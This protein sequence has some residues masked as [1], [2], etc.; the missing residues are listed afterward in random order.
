[1]EYLLRGI[2]MKCFAQYDWPHAN[3]IIETPNTAVVSAMIGLMKNPKTANTMPV[4]RMPLTASSYLGVKTSASSNNMNRF[5]NLGAQYQTLV[6]NLVELYTSKGV[7]VIL[8]LH[9]SNDDSEQQPMALKGESVGDASAFWSKVSADFADNELV[10]YELYNEP[11]IGDFDVYAHGNS[12]Y[13]GMI[14]MYEVVRANDPAGVVI[15]AG[16]SGYAYDAQSLVKLDSAWNFTNVMYNFH[17]YM[18]PNQQGD[19]RKSADGF[20]LMVK[21][22]RSGSDKPIIATEFGQYCCATNGSCYQYPGTYDNKKMG[23]T[24]AIINVCEKYGVSYT[25]WAWRPPSQTGNNCLDMNA[26]LVLNGPSNGQKADW[27][28]IWPKYAYN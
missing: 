21:G 28:T 11:H 2:G 19:A 25:P 1:M 24:E 13:T 10:F 14:E 18:G 3:K 16:Q 9:W 4:I 7:V 8:D 12:Q 20:E 15:I 17:P 26:G 22:V 23:Y 6:K 27:T 5:P